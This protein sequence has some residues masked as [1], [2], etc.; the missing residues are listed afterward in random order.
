VK[1][2]EARKPKGKAIF[3]E[4][5]PVHCSARRGYDFV[6]PTTGKI[7][8]K[9]TDGAPAVVRNSFGKGN[10]VFISAH[11]L[12]RCYGARERKGITERFPV[13]KKFYPG[14]REFVSGLAREALA[15]KGKE[16]PFAVENCPNEVETVMRL[17]NVDGGERRILHLLNYAFEAPVQGVKIEIPIQNDTPR[18]F[19]PIDG[20]PVPFERKGDRGAFVVRDFDV[21]EAIVIEKE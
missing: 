5:P 12:G 1:Y 16:L 2:I 17:Q 7:T 15:A 14:I 19:Y 9:W 10:C 21:H 20:K 4:D 8:S 18:I 3:G 11:D 6:E 13:Y